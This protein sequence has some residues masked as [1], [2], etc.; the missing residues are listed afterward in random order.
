MASNAIPTILLIATPLCSKRSFETPCVVI[1]HCSYHRKIDRAKEGSEHANK[2]TGRQRFNQSLSGLIASA[3][4][5]LEPG[6]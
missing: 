5:I 2:K 3:T 4:G 6:A 1:D